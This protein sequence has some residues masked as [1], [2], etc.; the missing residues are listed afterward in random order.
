MNLL[1]SIVSDF[2]KK[3]GTHSGKWIVIAVL[4]IFFASCQKD[5]ICKD[6]SAE[7]TIIN[8][9]GGYLNVCFTVSPSFQYLFCETDS[10]TKR[11]DYGDYWHKKITVQACAIFENSKRNLPDTVVL[12]WEHITLKYQ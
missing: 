9:T 5:E 1:F 7:V 11:L 3:M 12:L 8:K 6:Y 4:L 10:T 2:L